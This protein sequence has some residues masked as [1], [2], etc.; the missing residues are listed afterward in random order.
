MAEIVQ[1]HPKSPEKNRGKLEVF[2]KLLDSGVALLMLD[3]RQ[4]GVLVPPKFS[5]QPHL[6]LKFSYDFGLTDFGFDTR[7]VSATLSFDEGY[8]F[9]KVPWEA[10]F[11]IGDHELYRI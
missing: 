7:G 11:R 5:G 10:V 8:F 4:S 2:E 9:C 6:G 3:P 1:L